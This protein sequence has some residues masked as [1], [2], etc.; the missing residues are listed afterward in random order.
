MRLALKNRVRHLSKIALSEIARAG[1]MSH[2]PNRLN[3]WVG[4]LGYTTIIK[5]S[6]NV[7][8]KGYVFQTK[9]KISVQGNYHVEL[10]ATRKVIEEDSP[11]LGIRSLN[12]HDF[13]MLDIGANV[14]TFSVGAAGIGAKMVY[15]VEPGPLFARLVSNI[16]EN[17][18]ENTITAIQT[19]L[20]KHAGKMRWY[21]DKNNPGNAHLVTSKEFINFEKIPTK[22]GNDYVEVSVSTLDQ[23]RIDHKIPRVDLVKI[24]VEG[25][26]W[27]VLSAGADLIRSDLPTIVAETHRVASDMMG[28]DCMTPMF[29]FLYGLGYQSYTHRAGKFTK[30]IYPNFELD[31]FFIHPKTHSMG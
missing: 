9:N 8:Y 1:L 20:A 31:T 22:F 28:Y 6:P 27:E 12:L 24:D 18:L 7:R 26:E 13:V 23:L 3:A 21:E 19:G 25:M 29:E 5:R 2:M 11:F 17:N 14:G 10:S 4:S 16:K 30:F 15:A